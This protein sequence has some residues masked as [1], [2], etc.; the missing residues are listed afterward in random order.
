ESGVVLVFDRSLRER[1]SIAADFALRDMH[2]IR[3]H[4]GKLYVTCSF[5]NLVGVFDGQ[6][7]QQ[8]FP[9]GEPAT[10]LRDVNHFNTIEIID[11]NLCLLAHNNGASEVLVFDAQTLLLRE[12]F[13]LGVQ[14]HNIWKIGEEWCVCSSAE[15]KLIGTRGFEVITG[16]F[17]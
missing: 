7:W 4:A 10:E 2:Q 5:D 6:S 11:T 14:A 13:A 15:G 8:W 9:L 16:G 12:R 1:E 3:T 17:P